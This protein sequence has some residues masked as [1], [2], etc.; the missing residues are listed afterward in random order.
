MKYKEPSK[1]MH[2]AVWAL[3][4]GTIITCAFSAYADKT[5]KSLS[6]SVIRLHVIANSDRDVDQQLK[7][8]VRD[9]VI[10][11]AGHIFADNSDIVVAREEINNNIEN[12]CAVAQRTVSEQGYD[13]NVKVSLGKSDFPTKTYGGVVLPAGTYEALKVVIGDGKGKNWWCV[14]FP[15]LCFVDA[16][17]AQ[18]PDDSKQILRSSLT[19]SEYEMITANGELPVEVRFKVYEMWQNSK[20]K[21]KNMIASLK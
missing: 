4:I 21:L 7:L 16:T 2:H 3:C 13:Y 9:A 18:I 20:L 8:A 12:I 6:D 5:E 1:A 17:T 14:M 15:P 11:E 19:E 10:A